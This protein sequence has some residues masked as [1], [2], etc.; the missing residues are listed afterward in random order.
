MAIFLLIAL[1]SVDTDEETTKVNYPY[2][3][4]NSK[5]EKT[6]NNI[7]KMDLYA[8]K[9]IVQIDTLKM[10]CQKQKRDWKNGAFYFVV[11]FD[12]KSNAVFPNNPLTALHNEEKALRHIKAVYTYN[13]IN[14]YSKLNI[15]KRNA[16][17]SVAQEID[18]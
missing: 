4:V 11:F 12:D 2:E 8:I 16:W 14:G 6:G 1:G 5:T 18:I 7:N 9:D 10:F 13:R 15:Y 17:E 3:F